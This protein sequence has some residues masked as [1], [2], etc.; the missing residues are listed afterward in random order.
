MPETQAGIL[1]FDV[2]VGKRSRS[3][4][5]RNMNQKSDRQKFPHV[6]RVTCHHLFAMVA[7]KIPIVLL[8][9][10]CDLGRVGWLNP[11]VASKKNGS[12]WHMGNALTFPKIYA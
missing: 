7:S 6:A 8:V 11:L 5:I 1:C 4:Q 2:G 12:G 9:L 3:R 10:V